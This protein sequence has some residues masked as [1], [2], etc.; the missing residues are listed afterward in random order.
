MPV[1]G[2]EGHRAVI[3][4]THHRSQLPTV[5]QEPL[6]SEQN[7]GSKQN[8]ALNECILAWRGT[9][10]VLR[11]DEGRSEGDARLACRRT[12]T[13]T[14]SWAWARMKRAEGRPRAVCGLA[15]EAGHGSGGLGVWL[16]LA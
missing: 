15:V 9:Q 11:D 3:G 13:H 1:T 8:P 14:S 5:P 4:A 12:F 16:D 7:W 2:R 10:P 6:L